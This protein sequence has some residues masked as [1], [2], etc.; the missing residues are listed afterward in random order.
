VPVRLYCTICCREVGPAHRVSEAQWLHQVILAPVSILDRP[1]LTE[2]VNEMPKTKKAAPKGK[3]IAGKA[4]PKGA[5]KAAAKETAKERLE[6]LAE[7]KK[8]AKSRR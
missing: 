2:G 3:V 8:A 5:T 1:K 4:P 7:E 6:R